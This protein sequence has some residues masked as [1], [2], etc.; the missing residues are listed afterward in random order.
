MNLDNDNDLM[1][2]DPFDEQGSKRTKLADPVSG[3]DITFSDPF[4]EYVCSTPRDPVPKSKRSRTKSVSGI[5]YFVQLV[6]VWG[7]GGVVVH[8]GGISK[9]NLASLVT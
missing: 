5:K 9:L 8:L 4:E 6:C 2:H 1:I 7:G 3:E